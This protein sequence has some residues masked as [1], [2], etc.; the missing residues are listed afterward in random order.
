MRSRTATT[1]S[2]P[3]A[4]SFPFSL[5]SSVPPLPPPLRYDCCSTEAA[6]LSDLINLSSFKVKSNDLNTTRIHPSPSGSPIGSAFQSKVR[7]WDLKPGASCWRRK[8]GERVTP[9]SLV[10]C[11]HHIR[12]CPI[13]CLRS[14]TPTVSFGASFMVDQLEC[15][16]DF[17]LRGCVI[18]RGL[19]IRSS[20]LYFR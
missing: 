9:P 16:L 19:Y 5:P 15:F 7:C 6:F 17:L 2:S 1:T 3:T 13:L 8:G 11:N 12:F 10:Q 20:S 14:L 18:I 4:T